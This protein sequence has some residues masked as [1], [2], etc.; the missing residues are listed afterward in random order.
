MTNALE[1]ISKAL[2]QEGLEGQ[3]AAPVE[4]WNPPYCGDIDM[5]IGR[6]GLWYYMGTPIGRMALVKLFASV[7]LQD[8]EGKTY[9]VTPVEKIGI[10]VEDGHFLGVEMRVE[11]VNETQIISI[12]TQT[13]EWVTIGKNH[14][15]SFRP[16]QI[17][18]GEIGNIVPYV[19]MRGRLECRINRPVFY[20]LIELSVE[21]KIENINWLGI[22]SSGLFFPMIETHLL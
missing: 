3:K 1:N 2:A 15:L 6:D 11:G 18:K 4:K 21:R 5:R 20:D 9:L 19:H 8:E 16:D 10:I 12:R 7:L 22:W 13:E 17:G 14:P